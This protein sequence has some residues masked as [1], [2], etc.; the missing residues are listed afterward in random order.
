MAVAQKMYRDIEL[1][2][3]AKVLKM[4]VEALAS[5]PASPNQGQMYWDTTLGKFGVYTGTQWR[6]SGQVDSIAAAS[7]PAITI[8]GT[9]T[10]PTIAIAN[11]NSSNPGLM[12]SAHYDDLTN[13]TSAATASTIVERDASGK[14]SFKQV[15]IEDASGTWVATSAVTKEY[16]DGLIDPVMKSADSYDPTATG[17]YPTAYKTTGAVAE[18]DTFFITVAG[19][20][21]NGTDNTDDT[22]V[23][24]GDL[25]VANTDAPGNTVGNWFVLES[26]R[27]QATETVKGV[28]E[29]ATQA[30]VTTGTD[31]TR[32]VTPLKLKTE[33]DSRE[34]GSSYSADAVLNGSTATTVSHN[35]N[36]TDLIV[37]VWN[38]DGEEIT[39]GVAIDKTS[40]NAITVDANT[41]MTVRVNI[42]VA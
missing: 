2:S 33:L 23:N 28:A 38:P 39:A 6:Y 35:L 30:E 26:N 15:L 41:A 22:I 1:V 19:T 9:A 4:R 25:L 14:S 40:V 27:D 10:D 36:T 29:L 11:A 21:G 13:A 31:D 8:G 34:S 42:R 17:Q 24:V 7:T 3:G 37:S 12:T 32:I 20:M 16:V 5:S 18:G